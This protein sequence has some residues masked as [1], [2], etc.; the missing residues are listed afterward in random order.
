MLFPNGPVAHPSAIKRLSRQQVTRGAH[1]ASGGVIH[2]HTAGM[3]FV[4][5]FGVDF[6]KP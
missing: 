1:R 2:T 4:A 3:L 5:G 6:A